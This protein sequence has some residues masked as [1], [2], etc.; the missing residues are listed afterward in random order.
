MVTLST[1]RLLLRTIVESDISA[2]YEYS[3]QE[4]V[5]PNAGWKPHASKQETRQI[6]EEIFIRK[7]NVWGIVL[8]QSNQLI[9]TIGLIED[10][11]RENKATKMIGYAISQD[12]W[13]KGIMTEAAQLVIEY[14]FE[15]LQLELLS[16][17]CYPFNNR[18]KRVLE[19][20]GFQKEGTLKKAEKRYD[21]KIYDDEC[22][23]I[24]KEEY[25]RR[26]GEK[27]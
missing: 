9:G 23:A 21:G 14:A 24:T 20:C 18:S 10:R 22:Y 25:Q 7:E 26:K 2:I 6:A 3:K 15:I 19:K 8:K 11:K 12:Y 1:D 5:G 17:Y 27:E 13:G 4:K 16:A